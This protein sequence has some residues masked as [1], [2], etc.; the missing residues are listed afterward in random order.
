MPRALDIAGSPLMLEGCR[1]RGEQKR[2]ERPGWRAGFDLRKGQVV[3]VKPLRL[4]VQ[5]DVEMKD[6]RPI[7]TLLANQRGKAGWLEKVLTVE[8]ISGSALLRRLCRTPRKCR[9]PRLVVR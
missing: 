6:S 8:D 7:V 3:W 5:T 9:T 2:F 4:D 1:V